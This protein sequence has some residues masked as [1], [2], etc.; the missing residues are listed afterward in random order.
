M[1]LNLFIQGSARGLGNN[2]VLSLPLAQYSFSSG[3]VILVRREASMN[4]LALH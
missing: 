2:P 3:P 1:A 4:R